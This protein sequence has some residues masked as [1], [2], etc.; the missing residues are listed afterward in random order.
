[1]WFRLGIFGLIFPAYKQ[2]SPKAS[3]GK[4][5][6][7]IQKKLDAFSEHAYKL[8]SVISLSQNDLSTKEE[9]QDGREHE[10]DK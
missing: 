7:F 1:M 5:G 2:P 10:Q 8:L 3:A 9:E 4:L 6:K